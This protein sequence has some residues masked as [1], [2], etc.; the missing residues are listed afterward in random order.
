[1]ILKYLGIQYDTVVLSDSDS[2]TEWYGT[3]H[4]YKYLPALIDNVDG[5]RTALWDSTTILSYLSE[6]YDPEKNLYG[7][8]LKERLEIMNWSIFETASLG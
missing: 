1:M 8:T 2:G 6:R 3:I 4:P 7:R 5:E